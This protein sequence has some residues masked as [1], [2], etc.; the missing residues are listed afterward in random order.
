LDTIREPYLD[1]AVVDQD[2][3][4]LEIGLL[5][6]RLVVEA[7]EGVAEAITCDP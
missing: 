3:V 7:Q 6:G 4:H 2:I 5:A 1:T